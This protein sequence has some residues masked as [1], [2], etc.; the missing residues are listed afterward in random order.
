MRQ[1]S[2]EDKH[3]KDEDKRPIVKAKVFKNETNEDEVA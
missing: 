1:A 3:T 2:K